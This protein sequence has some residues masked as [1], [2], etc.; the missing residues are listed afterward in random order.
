MNAG[1]T[2]VKH[3]KRVVKT[4]ILRQQHPH[5]VL[6]R[7]VTYRNGRQITTR[8]K[9]GIIYTGLSRVKRKTD[10]RLTPVAYP[11]SI[12]DKIRCKTRTDDK[13]DVGCPMMKEFRAERRRLQREE[14]KQRID[15]WNDMMKDNKLFEQYSCV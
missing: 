12:W 8:H 3:E 1:H 13:T 4:G 7:L 10:I 9:F 14:A 2:H 6:M 15:I 5:H 11:A